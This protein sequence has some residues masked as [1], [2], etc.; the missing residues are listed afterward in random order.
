MNTRVSH[1]AE[2]S[3]Y[4]NVSRIDDRTHTTSGRDRNWLFL[5]DAD[6]DPRYLLR[7]EEG[8]VVTRSVKIVP[9]TMV[10]GEP[11]ITVSAKSTL[12][13]PELDAGGHVLIVGR[14]VG[15]LSWFPGRPEYTGSNIDGGVI[16]KTYVS[17]PH[18]RKGVATA[19]LRHARDLY[20]EKDI[21]H[22][23]ALSAD[24]RAFAAATPTPNDLAR[25]AA[26]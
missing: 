15:Y 18:R 24:G 12:S 11:T 13:C 10:H 4:W 5:D 25:T 26:A 14:R 22:S 23:D 21:R 6:G 7:M 3:R 19:M 9:V 17:S 2:K 1:I 8:A 20:P 16:H